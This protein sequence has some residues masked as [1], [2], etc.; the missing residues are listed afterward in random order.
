MGE[1]DLSK[2]DSPS[3]SRTIVFDQ[4]YDNVELHQGSGGSC[5]YSFH[6]YSSEEFAE[7]FSDDLPMLFG[8]VIAFLFLVMAATFFVYDVFV[9]RRN[10][11]IMGAAIRS[12]AIVSELFPSNVHDRLYGENLKAGSSRTLALAASS[13]ARLKRFVDE[14]DGTFETDGD[15]DDEELILK[16]KPIADLFPETTVMFA[17]IGTLS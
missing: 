12:T 4:F 10:S 8:L 14:K 11:K 2:T 6:V 5:I 3:R 9:Q 17:D 15:Y 16:S 13:T 1:G 7:I